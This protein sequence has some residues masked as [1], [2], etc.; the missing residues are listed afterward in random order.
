MIL[1]CY[2]EVILGPFCCMGDPAWQMPS[3]IYVPTVTEMIFNLL[4]VCDGRL[5]GFN[6]VM[7]LSVLSVVVY[8]CG[9]G[10]GNL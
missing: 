3:L 2:I 5:L 8:A 1:F 10:S 9:W 4:N 6:Q 7:S